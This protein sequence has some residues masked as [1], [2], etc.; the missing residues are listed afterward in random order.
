M[1][2]VLV[3]GACGKKEPP[4]ASPAPQEV[5]VATVTPKTVPATFE[6]VA[7]A[8][9]SH[10]VEIVARVSGFLEKILYREG[11][12]VQEGQVMFQMDQK[13]FQ[14]QVNAS[15][16][17][18]ENRKAQLWTAKA[19]LD[20]IKPLA[21]QDAASKSDLDN[22]VGTVQSA[23]A[24]VYE[25]QAGL[26]KALLDLSYTVIKSPLT[27]VSSKAL[28]REGAYLSASGS[29]SKLTYVAKLNPIWID[30][31]ISQNQQAK[32]RQEVQQ[33]L[34]VLP[35]D[36]AFEVE[37]EL[38]D[39][40]RYPLRGKVNFA[41]PSFSKETGTFQVRAE[42]PNPKEELRPGMFVKASLKGAVRPN[43][44]VVPQ[45]AVQQ[46]ANGHT[47]YV[48]NQ[49]EQA[50]IRP[51]IVGDWIGE[52][53]IINNGLNAGDRVIVEGFQRLAP[54]AP[55]KVVLTGSLPST[56]AAPQAGSPAKAAPAAPSR[57]ARPA[58]R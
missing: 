52:D 55:V 48:V 18:V 15:K 17:E 37:L 41:D 6:F 43:A 21:E 44:V 27:G 29:T 51:V 1:L 23:E 54:G 8:E 31:N 50:E 36:E 35:K 3:S 22:A 14:A 10:Q 26:D 5:T 25:A 24:A 42:V 38:S 32:K 56:P 58:S 11:E 34:L 13:P 39:G 4:E 28:L 46:T 33:G 40:V 16:G 19:N 9:S 47:V 7:Q 57:A 30:F 49:K 20:R 2:T 12:V 45:K 53:W